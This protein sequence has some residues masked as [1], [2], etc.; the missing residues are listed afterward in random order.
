MAGPSAADNSDDRVSNGNVQSLSEKIQDWTRDRIRNRASAPRHALLDF[1][2]QNFDRVTLFHALDEV[3]LDA[4][5]VSPCLQLLTNGKGSRQKL[6]KRLR[7]GRH[8]IWAFLTAGLEAKRNFVILGPPGSGKTT[9]LRYIASQLTSESHERREKGLPEK[10]PILLNVRDMN[11]MIADHPEMPLAEMISYILGLRGVRI[12]S[13]WFAE[14]L[15]GGESIISLD[16]LDELG[17]TDQRQAFITWL[18]TQMSE[19]SRSRFILTSHS[20]AYVSNRLSDVSVLKLAPFEDEGVYRLVSNWQQAG[21]WAGMDTNSEGEEATVQDVAEN[22]IEKLH[23]ATG[24]S[25]LQLNPAL[26]GMMATVLRD[27]EALPTRLSDLYETLCQTMFDRFANSERGGGISGEQAQHVLGALAFG[28]LQRNQ[29]EITPQ[30][31]HYDLQQPLTEINAQIRSTGFLG[32]VAAET[33]L[34]LESS[35]GAFRFVH[36]TIQEF[37]V[38]AYLRRQQLEGELTKNLE[39]ERWRQVILHYAAL[40]NASGIIAT[41]LAANPV[42]LAN[43]RLAVE[44]L[45]TSI[46]V[47]PA[48]KSRLEA[49]LRQEP[50]RDEDVAYRQGLADILVEWRLLKL[51][52]FDQDRLVDC[53]LLTQTEYQSF[54]SQQRKAG[55]HRQPDHWTGEYSAPGAGGQPILGIRPADAEAFC[56]WLNESEETQWFYRLPTKNE[57][58]NDPT[59]AARMADSSQSGYWAT[60]GDSYACRLPSNS[61][62]GT[63]PAILQQY[64]QADLAVNLGSYRDIARDFGLDSALEDA[65]LYAG[66][67]DFESAKNLRFYRPIDLE[68]TIRRAQAVGIELNVNLQLASMLISVRRRS[69][70]IASHLARTSTLMRDLSRATEPVNLEPVSEN[71]EEIRSICEDAKQLVRTLDAALESGGIAELDVRAVRAAAG[72]LLATLSRVDALDRILDRLAATGAEF[73]DHPDLERAR[74]AAQDFGLGEGSVLTQARDLMQAVEHSLSAM[75]ENGNAGNFHPD[76]FRNI[77]SD[78]REVAEIIRWY[79]RIRAAGKASELQQQLS[80][81][82]TSSTLVATQSQLDICLNVSS[83]TGFCGQHLAPANDVDM[84]R[85]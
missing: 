28:M 66:E 4:I 2:R 17:N 12:Q 47:D 29:R 82:A 3:S 6:P 55:I 85:L 61:A 80:T 83:S 18:E 9:L 26:L 74:E 27:Y 53:S 34:I 73:S 63:S 14:T 50:S 38:A 51:N 56:A 40:G 8:K 13:S 24:L 31:A 45:E 58:V 19:Y 67:Y 75:R 77:E 39:D 11:S 20:R 46:Y 42:P 22:F 78:W 41:C 30:D 36:I 72:Q 62:V 15:Y 79:I 21:I 7:T 70:E 16:G 52:R 5:F 81:G 60:A 69:R 10:L 76:D 71:I 57:F 48:E 68:G 35:Y 54:L 23:A 43:L 33:G 84:R 32:S 49:I 37:L 1:A 25:A 44:C 64:Q 59:G 65:L